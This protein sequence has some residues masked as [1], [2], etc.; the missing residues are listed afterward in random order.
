MRRLFR[1][2]RGESETFGIEQLVRLIMSFALG[3]AMLGILIAVVF[4]FMGSK[5]D[6]VAQNALDNVVWLIDAQT[7]D[8]WEVS[9]HIPLQW[10]N[11]LVGFS[12]AR[13]TIAVFH[14]PSSC[15]G[16][17]LCV[18]DVE[19]GDVETMEQE[20][21]AVYCREVPYNVTG[22]TSNFPKPAGTKFGFAMRL[23]SDYC[24]LVVI[25]KNREWI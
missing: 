6:K 14:R 3:V 20:S 10:K 16:N 24:T 13:D 9:T 15:V 25:K 12:A 21:K 11:S 23:W 8:E 17:C 22:Y 5:E 4:L 7:D 19:Y 2:R 18:F 1:S